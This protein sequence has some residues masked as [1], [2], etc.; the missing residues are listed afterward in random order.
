MKAKRR[1]IAYMILFV[2]TA[3]LILFLYYYRGRIGNIIEPFALAIII[4]YLLKPLVLRLEDKKIPI[5]YGIL[6]IYLLLIIIL[7]TVTFFIVPELVNSSRELANTLPDMAKRYEG[8]INKFLKTI[9]KSNWSEEFKSGIFKEIQNGSN[10]IQNYISD[11]LKKA[12]STFIETMSMF[13]N[14]LLAMV[15]AYYFLKDA[16]FFRDSALSLVPRKWRN[17]LTV[18][19]REINSIL[20]NFIQ[21]QLL[22]ALIVGVLEIIG[23]FI[24]KSKYPLV[25]GVIGGI[26]NVIPYFGPAI[27]AV[28]AVAIALIESPMKAVWT[29]LVFLIVQQIDNNFISP[30]IIEG[31][32]GLHPVTTIL[33]VLV[34]GEFFG[35]LGMLLGVPVVAI[36]KVLVKRTVDA[37]A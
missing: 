2:I 8:I 18:T 4:A 33:A 1:L 27:G 36:L 20:S 7:S 30:K 37:I 21:G 5:K 34:G 12:L 13:L 25:L 24:V 9:Q 11:S 6:I 28:P 19:A 10:F 23:L 15:I 17:W 14:I 29:A 16:D 22:T 3:L 32:L 35:I 31:R 26:A